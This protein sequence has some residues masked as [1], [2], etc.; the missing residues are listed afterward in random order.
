MLYYGHVNFASKVLALVIAKVMMTSSITN[1]ITDALVIT[2]ML[3]ISMNVMRCV[4]N[5]KT[6]LE[7]IS[8]SIIELGINRLWFAVRKKNK[9][10]E[11]SY[12]RY[13]GFA[14]S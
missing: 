13:N 4:E 3:M 12:G 7:R 1:S 6:N 9:M 8:T 5:V 11:I 10:R 14:I 2:L